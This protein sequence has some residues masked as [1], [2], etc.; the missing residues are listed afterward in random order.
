MSRLDKE[1]IRAANRLEDVIAA[2]TGQ[3]LSRNG[4]QEVAFRCLL[5]GEDRHPSGRVNL[6]KQ[7]WFCD[8]CKAGG[9]VIEFVIRHQQTD[10][11]GALA[12]LA[13]RTGTQNAES[14]RSSRIVATFDYR[15]L[16]GRLLYQSCRK[17]PGPN[18]KKKTFVQRR[19]D[20]QDGWIYNMEGVELV[21]YRLADLQ[22]KE[23][24]FIVEGERKAD[25]LWEL[26]L[27]ATC[28]V[29]GAGK[30][31]SDYAKSIHGI[32][33]RRVAILG[34]NDL[35]GRKHVEADVAPSCL[36]A[37]I[38]AKIVELPDL[39]PKG[40][41]I[42]WLEAGHTRE[43][44]LAQ[45]KAAPWFEPSRTTS[46]T[47]IAQPAGP[48]ADAS[49]E[50]L[51]AVLEPLVTFIRRFVILTPEQAT[52]IGLWVIHT[53][54]IAA[55][56]YKAYLQITSATAEAG[57]TRL[58]EV[59]RLL[60]ARP[61]FTGR[62]SAA[63]L[64][65]KIDAEQ[66]TFLL[67]EGD[68]A[69]NGEKEYTEALRSILNTGYQRNGTASLCVGQ[70][71]NISYKDFS[72][73]C[74]KAIAGIG[75]LPDTVA[76]RAIRIELKRRAKNEPIER[77]RERDARAEADRIRES[78]VHLVKRAG[79]VDTLRTARPAMPT[80]LR[81]RAE[82]VVEPLL[83]IADLAGGD[84]PT[85]ARHAVVALMGTPSEQDLN[86]EL[87][88]DIFEV[89]EDSR[90]SF[91]V[92][93]EL[94]KKLA[95]LDSR[96]WADWKNGR[97]L[98]TRALADRLRPF[99]IAPTRNPTATKRGYYRDRFEDAWTRY[100]PSKATSRQNTHEI[101]PE[102]A[103]STRQTFFEVDASKSEKTSI[104]TASPDA[105]T[106]YSPDH[107]DQAVPDST[108]TLQPDAATDRERRGSPDGHVRTRF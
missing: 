81:D 108:D 47:L 3:S 23:A 24:A 54:A 100:P 35:P 73:F 18:G 20:D 33:V 99:G 63:V 60:V 92:S 72:T 89:F 53:H 67:D 107:E 36:E 106:L 44:I 84:W 32:G 102:V 78:I 6:E 104:N 40:D 83:A 85:R 55:A 22:G 5:H 74:A 93:E 31:N 87:L 13:Q 16:E 45:V 39:P 49:N 68:A 42:D 46:T 56:V 43:D 94:A 90:A 14:A 105:L 103:I 69:F 25:R 86:V 98:S 29:G 51:A 80:G 50:G 82:D 59:L 30:W 70:G 64:V 28:N 48:T 71:A 91:M 27:P 7:Q 79:V 19:P 1:A 8:V 34:D 38:T 15:D 62:V 17:E 58:L 95:E 11:K 12:W 26:G 9:D 57:K 66:P 2:L 88:H 75:K 37:G 65:R 52:A 77:F 97:P 76:S 10:F 96:P 4:S 41:V 21:P 61:W 101:G